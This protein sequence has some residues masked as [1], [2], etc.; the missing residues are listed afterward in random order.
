MK[1]L[2]FI[3]FGYLSSGEFTIAA[4]FAKRLPTSKYNIIFL[5]SEEGNNFLK[6]NGFNTFVVKRSPTISK[7]ENEKL[8]TNFFDNFKPDLFLISDIY[9]FD[10]S[11]SWSGIKLPFL[12][13]YN[14]KIINF[15]EYEYRNSDYVIDYYGNL[16]SQLFNLQADCDYLLAHCPLNKKNNK[17]MNNVFYFSL[18]EKKLTISKDKKEEIRKRF[19]PDGKSKIIFTAT[20]KWESLN[21]CNFNSLTPLLK[22]LPQIILNYLDLLD[23]KLTLIHVGPQ[24]WD[25]DNFQNIA[26]HHFSY[27]APSEFDDY[28]LS[29]DLFITT[30][31]VSVTLSKAIYGNIPSILI[32][33]NKIIDFKKLADKLI[34]LPNWYQKMAREVEI[35]YPYQVFPFGWYSFLK[36]VMS[37]NIYMKTFIQAPLFQKTKCLELI[38]MYLLDNNKRQELLKEQNEYLENVLKLPTPEEIVLKWE[39]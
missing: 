33:N 7:C 29:S 21:V 8:I 30:N 12:K 16:K 20:S 19:N 24:K 23:I 4:E 31:L 37:E 11:Y 27:L 2:V 35:A 32:N 34:N 25:T 17:D 15:D 9:T 28:I 10:Y 14:K 18:Y 1:N 39:K 13:K 36:V 26:Y 6:Q 22:W 38:K 3:T 5:S